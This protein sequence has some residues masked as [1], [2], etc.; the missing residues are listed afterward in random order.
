MRMARAGLPRSGAQ[1]I[2]L[3]FEREQTCIVASALRFVAI[4]AGR[5]PR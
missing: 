2:H 3:S 1:G 5:I 4:K